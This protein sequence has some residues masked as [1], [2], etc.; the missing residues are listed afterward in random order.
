MASSG[1]EI[2]KIATLAKS[3]M[4]AVRMLELVQKARTPMIGLCMG[5]EGIITRILAAKV[6]AF[7]M[8]ASAARG[9]ESGPGRYLMK[10]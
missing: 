8:F 2:V 5:E 9:S 4:D 10:R 1:A 3:I 7:L 6:G